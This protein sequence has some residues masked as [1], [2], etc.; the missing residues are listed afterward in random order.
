MKK[1]V[2]APFICSKLKY[3]TQKEI[4]LLFSRVIA[5]HCASVEG[6]EGY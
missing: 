3:A 6:C 2:T 1:K 4:G 5:C